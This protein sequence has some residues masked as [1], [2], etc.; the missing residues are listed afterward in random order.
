MSIQAVAWVLEHSEA[1]LADRLVL[2]AIANHCDGRGVNAW[3]AAERIAHEAKVHRATV[4][5]ALETLEESGE[6]TVKRRPGRPNTYG[7]PSLMGSQ[8][9]TGR[10]VADCDGG[11]ANDAQR[12]RRLRP[13]PLRT[14]N[15][16]SP[17]HARE[18]IT[19]PNGLDSET[20]KRGVEF[21]KALRTGQTDPDI[22]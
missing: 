22:A 7:I 6:L 2:I 4:F 21:F 11:V 13:E 5:R 14:V 3:P 9:A 20:R 15:E 8:D 17:A 19:M 12:G 16:P 10:G 1:T 18:G